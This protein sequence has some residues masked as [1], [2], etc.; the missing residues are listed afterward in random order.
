MEEAIRLQKMKARAE[1]EEQQ[2]L[3]KESQAKEG[4]LSEE[5]QTWKPNRVQDLSNQWKTTKE[6]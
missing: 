2:R 4:K 6:Q 1:E 5:P 3:E